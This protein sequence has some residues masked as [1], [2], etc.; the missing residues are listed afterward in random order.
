MSRKFRHHDEPII[1][2][3][4][5]LGGML[6]VVGWISAL[7]TFLLVSLDKPSLEKAASIGD[8]FGSINSL[9][10][11]LAL[12]AAIAGTLI[13]G[14]EFRKQL[15]EMSK[16]AAEM[17]KQTATY[18]AQ[19][20]QLKAQTDLLK[21]QLFQEKLSGRLRDLPFF[22]VDR[23]HFK[24]SNVSI[25]VTHHGA[26]IFNVSACITSSGFRTNGLRTSSGVT[27]HISRLVS[28]DSFDVCSGH[29]HDNSNIPW[30][31]FLEIEYFLSSGEAMCETLM[32]QNNCKATSNRCAQALEIE[33]VL[34]GLPSRDSE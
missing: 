26:T 28:N 4:F 21:E 6:L 23:V 12:L 7:I 22:F 8:A 13:Q 24:E 2:Q 9:F 11:I 16:S 5:T 29:D 3:Y 30:P 34:R 32:I 19:L 18:E 14:K 20:V 17:E 27:N 31:I 10:S 33:K 25:N 15:E 1:P